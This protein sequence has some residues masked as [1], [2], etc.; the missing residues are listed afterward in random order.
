MVSMFYLSIKAA[1]CPM[2]CNV[3][4]NEKVY[5]AVLC[6]QKMV[7]QTR[8]MRMTKIY[9]FQYN[10]TVVYYLCTNRKQLLESVG[11]FS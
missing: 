6:S 2:Q 8:I 3:F 5:V 9:Q 1:K 7:G 4:E 11:F 10:L